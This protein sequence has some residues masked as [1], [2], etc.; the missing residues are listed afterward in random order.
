MK[1]P[2]HVRYCASLILLAIIWTLTGVSSYAQTSEPNDTTTVT[3]KLTQN[4]FRP[5]IVSYERYGGSNFT[6]DTPDGESARGR[7]ASTDVFLANLSLP[8]LIKEKFYVLGNVGYQLQNHRLES[9]EVSDPRFAT[10]DV[11]ETMT[12]QAVSI[13]VNVIKRFSIQQRNFMIL[14]NASA[15]TQ[16]F[17]GPYQI[18]GFAGAGYV[19]PTTARFKGTVGLMG[20]LNQKSSIPVIPVATI[21]YRM[22]D[23]WDLDSNFPLYVYLRRNLN[24]HAWVGPGA[25]IRGFNFIF[26]AASVSPFS[27]ED[28]RLRNTEIR[29]GFRYEQRISKLFLIGAKAGLKTNFSHRLGEKSKPS[30]DYYL[31]SHIREALYFNVNLSFSPQLSR[32]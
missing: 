28:L 20:L 10:R 26:P 7:I 29:Y 8:I 12:H 24:E 11:P 9:V 19:F 13:G 18:T 32:K 5:L 27:G 17:S 1:Y 22:N 16:D 14:A 2:H 6:T 25:E 3:Q 21:Y 31:E 23:R 15:L 30:N 4:L